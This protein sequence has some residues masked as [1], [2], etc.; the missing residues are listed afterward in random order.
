M[1][2]NALSGD[3]RHF[4][5]IDEVIEAWRVIAPLTAADLTLHT[6]PQGSD[7]P[8]RSVG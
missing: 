4:A 6:Y 5:Q 3:R 7:G 8:D 1:L 2:D